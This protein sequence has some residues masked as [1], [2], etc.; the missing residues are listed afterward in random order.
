LDSS[1]IGNSKLD[2]KRLSVEGGRSEGED[3]FGEGE[4][5]WK[6]D[7]SISVSAIRGASSFVEG[8]F[9]DVFSWREPRWGRHAEERSKII[10]TAKIL[11]IIT[12]LLEAREERWNLKN[13]FILLA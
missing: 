11:G 1:L 9:G 8:G 3:S 13:I 6:E 2:I 4:I 12:F 7:F 10:P 5:S